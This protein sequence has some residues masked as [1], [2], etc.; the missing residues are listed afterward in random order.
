MTMVVLFPPAFVNAIL[1]FEG[2]TYFT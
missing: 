2:L 1:V